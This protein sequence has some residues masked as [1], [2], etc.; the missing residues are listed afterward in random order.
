MIPAWALEAAGA[1][2]TVIVKLL[3]ASSDKEREDAFMEAAEASKA[4]LDRAK[5]GG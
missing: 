4:A 5:F 3:S 2:A 1:L